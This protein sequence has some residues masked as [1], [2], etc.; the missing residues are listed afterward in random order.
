MPDSKP[1]KAQ[2]KSTQAQVASEK[3]QLVPGTQVVT[4]QPA[5]S[6]PSSSAAYQD[7]VGFDP[8]TETIATTFRPIWNTPPAAVQQNKVT[9]VN[10]PAAS[11]ATGVAVSPSM[12]SSKFVAVPDMTAAVK[13]TAG[14]QVQIS[15]SFSGV[16]SVATAVASMALFRD[17]QQIG[18]TLHGSG[19]ASNA[20]F[21]IAQTFIDSPSGGLHAYSVYWSTNVGRLTAD[22]KN[23]VVHGLVLKPQ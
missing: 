8:P 15:W 13:A 6:Y 20:K 19:P 17:G 11:T 3:A 12:S 10:L 7:G 4:P 2:I 1:L 9:T 22:G 18:P 5:R 16:L 14:S 23:R 21:S